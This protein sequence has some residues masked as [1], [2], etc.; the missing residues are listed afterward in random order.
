MTVVLHLYIAG[1]SPNSVLARHNLRTICER[2]F[3]DAPPEVHVIDVLLQP[4]LAAGAGILVTPTLLK[5][6][7]QPQARIVGNLSQ[8]QVVVQALGGDYR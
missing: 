7:P 6:S 1:N 3:V 5:I 8:Q 2:F 4:Q